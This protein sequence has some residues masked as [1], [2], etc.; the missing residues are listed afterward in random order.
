MFVH[1]SA[2][3]L[4]ITGISKP[5][6]V[7]SCAGLLAAK[8]PGL[9][10]IPAAVYGFAAT[11]AFTL[12]SKDGLANL[13]APSLANPAANTALLLIIGSAFGYV[14]QQVAGAMAKA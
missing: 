4:S 14:S 7:R 9:S 5:V 3:S 13:A 10:S 8:V 1:K 6:N 12:L 11:V 2:N